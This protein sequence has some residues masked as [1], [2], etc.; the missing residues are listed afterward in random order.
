[1]ADKPTP[2]AAPTTDSALIAKA[3]QALADNQP[4][5]QKRYHEIVHTTP[6]WDGTSTRSVLT[7]EFYQ[8]GNL[9]ND[10]VLSNDEI[11]LINQLKP[12]VYA[13]NKFRVTKQPG[14]GIGLWYDNKSLKQRFDIARLAGEGEG[15]TG[16]LQKVVLEQEA[17]AMRRK[18]GLDPLGE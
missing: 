14:G 4:R 17:Q 8:N 18:K 12:G 16:I 13:K 11:D 3:L 10:V 5:R 1:M 6:W 7:R 2:E 9:V 15:L